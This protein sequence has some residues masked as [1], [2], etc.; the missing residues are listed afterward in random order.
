MVYAKKSVISIINLN[1]NDFIGQLM[2]LEYASQLNLS[3]SEISNGRFSQD[4]GG[5]TAIT[6]LDSNADVL[7]SS[8]YDIFGLSGS[9]IYA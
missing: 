4:N 9:A 5:G 6:L 1:A 2:F 3:F 7:S 8:F